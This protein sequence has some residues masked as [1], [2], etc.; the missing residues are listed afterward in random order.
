VEKKIEKMNPTILTDFFIAGVT[1]GAERTVGIG[2]VGLL[3]SLGWMVWLQFGM[4]G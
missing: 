4:W 2:N 1:G 3:G